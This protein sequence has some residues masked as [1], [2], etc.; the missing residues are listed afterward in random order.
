MPPTSCAS[1]AADVPHLIAACGISDGGIDVYID[2]RPRAE[3]GYDL[4]AESLA[5]YPEPETRE[6]FAEGGN[7]KDFAA[8]F[9]TEDAAAIK[10]ALLAAGGMSAPP[11][12]KEQASWPSGALSCSLEQ[13]PSVAWSRCP[14]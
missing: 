12:T 11:L 6:A 3:S 1:R 5:D 13:M 14:L 10:A 8:A 4:A 2:W 9:Y 7:R